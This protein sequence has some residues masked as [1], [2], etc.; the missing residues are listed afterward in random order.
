MRV[1][2]L[3]RLGG[4]SASA[5]RYYEKVGLLEPAS[6]T[7]SGYRVYHP[8]AIGRLQFLL[9]AKALGLSLHEVH[10]LLTSPNVDTA[11][12]RD[13]LRHLVAHKIADTKRRVAEL[14][15]LSRELESLYVRLLRAPALDCGHVG[16]CALWL[17]T[18]EE[19]RTMTEEV[20]CCG[21]LCCPSCAC[22]QGETCDCPECPCCARS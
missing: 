14:Q 15:D 20:Q 18:E 2:E 3:A 1:G 5:L 8:E 16:D 21:E 7:D 12:E 22:S 13:R 10:R 4:V 11:T 19:V 17:P 6:R 9:R